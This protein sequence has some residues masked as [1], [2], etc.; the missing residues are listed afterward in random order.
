[1]SVGSASS[2]AAPASYLLISSRSASSDSKRSSWACRISALR[3]AAGSN[4]LPGLVQHVGRH[5]H[6]RQRGAQLV[7][8]VG[9][10]APLHPGQVLELADLALQAGRHPVERRRQ[11]GQVVLAAHPHP[12]VEPARGE[13]LGDAGGHPDRRDDLPGDQPGD[14]AEQHDQGERAHQQRA[15]DQAE[16]VLLLVEREDVVELVRPDAGDLDRCP[17]D[18]DRHPP[19]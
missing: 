2:S 3:S 17:H 5:P 14:A 12:L 1:M 4:P 10:E 16:G 19:A 9:D 8:H 13:P 11:P 7:R 6:R 18:H 15:A